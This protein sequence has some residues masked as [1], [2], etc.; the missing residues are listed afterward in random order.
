MI[1]KW[2]DACDADT[3]SK[4]YGNFDAVKSLVPLV[5]TNYASSS[6][7]FATAITPVTYEISQFGSSDCAECFRELAL[8]IKANI[9]NRRASFADETF[10]SFLNYCKDPHG[11]NC[12]LMIGTVAISKFKECSGFDLDLQA[13]PT[14]TPTAVAY[15]SSSTTAPTTTADS[16]GNSTDS[17]TKSS[18]STYIS[19][20]A[21]FL[22]V[23][24]SQTI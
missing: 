17:S 9:V 24:I 5:I 2:Y 8:D 16:P 20:A 4:I 3:L 7:D 19:G 6:T 22:V 23:F 1:D 15:P 21:Y 12:P 13:V 11:S 18:E 10:A 14:S